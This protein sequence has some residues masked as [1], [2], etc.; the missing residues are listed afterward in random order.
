MPMAGRD[1]FTFGP[2]KWTLPTDRSVRVMGVVITRI[3]HVTIGQHQLMKARAIELDCLM[4]L[5]ALVRTL[6]DRCVRW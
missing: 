1:Y 2:D 6:F 3:Q 4:L 5:V